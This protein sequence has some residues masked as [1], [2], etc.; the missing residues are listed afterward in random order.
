MSRNSHLLMSHPSSVDR[1]ADSTDCTFEQ[2]LPDYDSTYPLDNDSP[3][4]KEDEGLDDDGDSHSAPVDDEDCDL[5]SGVRP[6]PGWLM[7]SFETN[8]QVIKNSV[9]GHGAAARVGIYNQLKSFW[10]PCIE[11]FFLLQ[12]HD[13]S[14]SLL[15]NPQFFYW[16]PL[17][18]VDQISC[19]K[20]GCIGR[21]TRHGYWHHP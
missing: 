8:L 12:Q 3:D 1:S 13:I 14:P 6:P 10:L 9:T 18:L 17:T 19:P 20:P 21:L 5:P 16:D 4:N 7:T 11:T 2:I 15:Y